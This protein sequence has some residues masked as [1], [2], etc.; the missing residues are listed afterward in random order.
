MWLR[1][2]LKCQS[3][4][5]LNL[6]WR[7]ELTKNYMP[8]RRRRDAGARAGKDDVVEGVEE[9]SAEGQMV[10][11][12]DLGIFFREHVPV[13]GA[14]TVHIA[15][16]AADVSEGELRRLSEGGGIEIEAVCA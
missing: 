15:E 8:E 7:V 14:R 10:A 1:A 11:L 12:A 6:P 4:A 5:E 2:T 9:L 3:E 13:P 16:I